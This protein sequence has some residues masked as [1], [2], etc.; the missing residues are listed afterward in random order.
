MEF[1][2][3]SAYVVWPALVAVA[4]IVGE[5]GH[6]L[7]GLPRI[8]LYGLA[9]F[10]FGQSP[11]A[12]FAAQSGF[13]AAALA[14]IAFGLILFEFGYR[15]NLRWLRLNPW[16]TVTGAA[17]AL[18]TFTAV[19]F[20][21]HHQGATPLT[22]LLLGAL[23]AS[24]S[25]ATVMRVINEERSAG[26]VTERILHLAAINCTIAVFAFKAVV[27]FWA[28]DSSGSLWVAISSS[29]LVLAASAALGALFGVC[30]PAL[31]RQTNGQAESATLVFAIAVV[32]LAT[33]ASAFKLSPSLATLTFGVL[34][35]ARRVHLA[36]T[37]RNFGALGDLLAVVLFTYIAAT[38]DSAR[39]V[40]GLQVGAMLVVT[41][42]VVKVTLVCALARVSG[43]SWRKGLLTGLALTP[44]SA[45]VILLLEQTR[46]MGVDLLD[47]VAPLAAAT[48]MLELLGPVMTQFALRLAGESRHNQERSRAAG[49]L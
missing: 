31:L 12:A 36:P 6:R 28:F 2:E 10:G 30:M 20:L 34:A 37:Q 47:Q 9:G 22:S 17:E 38:L 24:T 11:M 5:I 23:A 7:T 40:E 41:R 25:P 43:T 15:I 35:R 1:L 16:L 49:T 48:L 8:S 4:W 46:H 44:M 32:L 42:L 14:N 26:Q 13:N 33:T 39:V 19:A 3:S 18:A 45:F 29:V 27:G 21:A